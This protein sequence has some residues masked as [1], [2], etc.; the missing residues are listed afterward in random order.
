[1]KLTEK[2]IKAAPPPA[3][4]GG[5]GSKLFDG[6]GL[7][8]LVSP[9]GAKGWRLKY[10]FQSRERLL[11]LGTYPE[12]SITDARDARHDARK[13]LR[14]GIDPIAVRKKERAASAVTF[15]EVADGY[16]KKESHRSAAATQTKAQWQLKKLRPLWNCPLVEI[17]TPDVLAIVQRIE[18]HQRH[19]TAHR[20]RA[21]ASAVFAYGMQTGRCQNDPAAPIRGAL[22]PIKT[23]HHAGL[24]DP[25]KVG[26]LLR[27]IDGYE[28][29]LPVSYALRLLPRVFVRPGELRGARWNEFDL[30]AAEWRIPAARMKIKRPHLVPLSRQA[31]AILQAVKEVTWMDLSGLVFPSA[32]GSDKKLSDNTFNST[33]RRLGFDGDTQTAHGFRTTASTLLREKH[34]DGDLIELQ[35]AHKDK[36]AVRDAYNRAERLP[37]R[38]AMMQ[39]WADYL[40]EL[41]AQKS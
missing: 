39:A 38:R 16:L 4:A 21:L 31:V 10:T 3:R 34:F 22:I 19:E 1:M 2:A 5:T 41:K 36:N 37:E 26:E 15:K 13:L 29:T 9:T 12:T 7:Y 35:L 30:T 14:Q 11:A 17:T 24:T 33:L 20:V 18:A 8:L 6:E 25:K 28:G 32:N 27:A 40:E 23:T